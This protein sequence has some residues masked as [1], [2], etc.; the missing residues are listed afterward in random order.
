VI[1][2]TYENIRRRANVG[3]TYYMVLKCEAES[4]LLTETLPPNKYVVRMD[5]TRIFKAGLT[6]R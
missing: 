3:A 2:Q 4:K 5:N 1:K 6:Y